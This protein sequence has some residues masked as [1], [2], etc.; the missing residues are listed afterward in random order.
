MGLERKS[1]IKSISSVFYHYRN[2]ITIYT[3]DNDKDKKFYVTLFKRLLDGTGV[4]INDVFPLGDCDVVYST[5]QNDHSN[6][7]RLYIIDGDIFLMTTP[8]NSIEHL[9]ILP[10]YCIE[11]FVL[12]KQSFYRVFDE[13]DHLHTQEDIEGIVD[14]DSMVQNAV[15]PFLELFRYFAISKEYLGLFK[16]KDVYQFIDKT[17]LINDEKIKQETNEIKEDILN[18]GA[19]SEAEFSEIVLNKTTDYADT[20]DNLM[21]YASGKDYLLPYFCSVAKSKLSI[22]IGLKKENWKYQF[23]KYCDLSRL[24]DLRKKIIEEANRKS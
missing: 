1:E 12:D 18:F 17:A 15:H 24:S 4:V 8:K 14:Y 20:K 21:K 2:S 6:T 7:P 5:C 22:N 13:L 23:S 11:N 19:V 16:L 10:A 3:E 9:Y